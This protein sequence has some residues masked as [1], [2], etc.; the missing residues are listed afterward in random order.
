MT[1]LL[2]QSFFDLVENTE[3]PRLFHRWSLVAGVGALLA[4][5]YYLEFGDG[6][7]TPTMYVQLIG[8]PGSRKST[9]IKYVAGLLLDAGYNTFS[10]DRTSKEKFLL[11]LAG[12]LDEEY[13]GKTSKKEIMET[14]YDE[15]SLDPR[16]VFIC[17]DEFIEFIGSSNME[18]LS[19]LGNLWDYNSETPYKQRLKNSKSVEIYK[20]T[21]SILSGNTHTGFAQVFPPEASGGGFLSRMILVYAKSTGIK[22]TFPEKPPEHMR[23]I[24]LDNLHRIRNEV[25]G[26][27]LITGQAKDHLNY[28][29]RKYDGVGDMRF[30]HY[31]TRRFTQLLK[32]CLIISACSYRTEIQ[33]NDVIYANTLLSFTEHFMPDALGEFGRSKNSDVSTKILELLANAKQPMDVSQIWTQVSSDL[34]RPDALSQVLAGLVQSKKVQYIIKRPGVDAQGYLLAR[35]QLAKNSLVNYEW[36]EEARNFI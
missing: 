17:A 5:N 36:L 33:V 21:V 24:V 22:I 23:R 1:P 15:K 11:D 13:G 19:M 9:A 4:R 6:V 34:D 20:P 12:V 7:I 27:A 31:D 2:F 30:K 10:A 29:Y 25:Y 3:T 14:I 8:D 32:L 35:R 18:F 28:I 16:E 26:P